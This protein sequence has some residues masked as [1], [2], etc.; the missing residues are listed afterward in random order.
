MTTKTLATL[1]PKDPKNVSIKSQVNKD[2][3]TEIELELFIVIW[4]EQLYK[5]LLEERK[6]VKKKKK[7]NG[8]TQKQIWVLSAGKQLSRSTHSSKKGIGQSASQGT[9]L[10][11]KFQTLFWYFRLHKLVVRWNFPSFILFAGSHCVISTNHKM[12]SR[13]WR[14]FPL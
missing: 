4:G 12:V 3:A 10:T 1:W 7:K 2:R 9:W 14:L 13:I 5:E 11:F 8:G 6:R